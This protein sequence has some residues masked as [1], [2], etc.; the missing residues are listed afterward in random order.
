MKSRQLAQTLTEFAGMAEPARADEL[1]RLAVIF[2]T[3]DD[4]TVAARLKKLSRSHSH[5]A[6]LR[7]S[8]ES[9]RSGLAAAGAR[10]AAIIEKV[11][12]LFAG[13]G[14]AELTTFLQ[15]IATQPQRRPT[16][17]KA[18]A[19]A[20]L[21]LAKTL[22]DRLTESTLDTATFN[23]VVKELRSAKLV[24]TPTLISI[25]HRYLGNDKPYKGR[26]AAIDEIV[27]RQKADAREHARGKA[28]SR[29][30]V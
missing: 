5:P 15:E 6:G 12:T 9:I 30:G 24:N 29:V 8:L 27:G 20:D 28:L 1:R 22:A 17:A 25:A 10:Q 3:G 21:Q 11:L 19:A 18:P 4:D 13:P 26:K 2:E 14:D 7:R 16:R 23:E